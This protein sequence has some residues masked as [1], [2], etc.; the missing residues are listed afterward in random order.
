MEWLAEGEDTG[1]SLARMT[2]KPHSTSPLRRHENCSE[3]I[4]VFSGEIDQRRNRH[5]QKMSAGDTI[6]IYS[7]ETHQTRNLNDGEATLFVA[8]TSGKRAY[9]EVEA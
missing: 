6:T 4:H 5:W 1:L 9:E 3:V 7:G 8:Y 2:V